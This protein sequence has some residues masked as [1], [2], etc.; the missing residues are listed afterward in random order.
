M[1]T[2]IE[3]TNTFVLSRY[4]TKRVTHLLQM[5][6]CHFPCLKLNLLIYPIGQTCSHLSKLI[7]TYLNLSK[8]KLSELI[9]TYSNLSKPIPT[10]SN[11]SEPIQ[12]YYNISKPIQIYLHLSIPINTYRNLSIPIPIFPIW[13]CNSIIKCAISRRLG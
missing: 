4:L 10:N 11:Q 2:W 8:L 7:H 1:R 9:Q 13:T 3:V 12:T 5:Y 6:W